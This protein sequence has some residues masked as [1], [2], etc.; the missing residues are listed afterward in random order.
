ML[1]F[2]LSTTVYA[3]ICIVLGIFSKRTA[4]VVARLWNVHL[5][6]FCG[7]RLAVRGEGKLK[8]NGRYVFF[9]NHQSA[10]DIPVIYTGIRRP[11]CFIAK[12]ELF[13]IPIFGWGL[14]MVGHVKID[15]SSPR[16]ARLSLAR[17]IAHLRK[18]RLSLVL[19]PEGTRSADGRLGEFKQ[20]AF[21]LAIEAGVPV[22]PVAIIGS[23]ERLVKKSLMVNPGTIHLDIGN[24][25]DPK[26]MDKSELAIKVR[27]EIDRMLS[28]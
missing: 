6:F 23:R 25:I 18:H 3:S 21:S 27:S 2:V 10:L 8:P 13:R 12:K 17:G 24:P 1:W 28:V 22:V 5:L 19:F 7:V 9:A 11:I 20:G 26:G 15:R 14:S 16:K 4:H